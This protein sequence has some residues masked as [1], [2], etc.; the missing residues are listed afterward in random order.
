MNKSLS[1]AAVLAILA[2][3]GCAAAASSAG[4]LLTLEGKLVLKGSMPMVQTIL[5]LPDRQQWELQGVP[6]A[7]A[8][9]LQNRQVIAQGVVVRPAK[10]G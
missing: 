4:K 1:I 8:E 7:R 6:R 10:D 2:L 3:F 9:A 5:I